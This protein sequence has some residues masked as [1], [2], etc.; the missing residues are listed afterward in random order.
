M[1]LLSHLIVTAT[2]ILNV[3]ASNQTKFHGWKSEPESRGT[4]SIL[5]S[6]LATV[7]LCTWSVLY[8]DV[9]KRHGRWYLFYRKLGWM[10]LAI[11]A[12]EAIL[13]YSYLG[14][15]I[16]RR[17]LRHLA[18]QGY[19]EWILTHMQF[20]GAKGFRC[21]AP[22][23]S[24]TTECDLYY[25]YEL[26][27]EG[28][29]D[30]PPVSEDELRSRGKSDLVIKL[31]AILQI[32][33]FVAQ[34][35]V[36]AIEH[37]HITA[38]ELSTV[39]FVCCSILSYGFCISRPQDVEYPVVLEIPCV[40]NSFIIRT[41][42]TP[43]EGKAIGSLILG[44][45]ACGFGAIHCLAWNLP[46][47]TPQERLAWRICSVAMTALPLVIIPLIAFAAPFKFH[48]SKSF[49]IFVVLYA[50]GRITIIALAFIA[51]RALPVDA[52]HT[53]NWSKYMPHFS[54]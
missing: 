42:Q 23:T 19:K 44:I 40:P 1:V 13:S 51:L 52:F 8:L 21:H 5:W 28:H 38:L 22:D 6:C 12:P 35:L 41:L 39:A 7:F 53:V 54:G 4:W 49:F 15:S 45:S 24:R 25:L 27:K 48:I 26:I 11:I 50:I 47:P 16:A 29:L 43:E 18:Q 9:L 2:W 10:L 30:R 33:W 14:Y 32:V 20:A 31:I 36:R 3:Q 46:F 17:V 34:T 37:Y